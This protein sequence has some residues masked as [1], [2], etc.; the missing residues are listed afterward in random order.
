MV[1]SFASI[2][3]AGLKRLWLLVE[4]TELS[5]TAG[6]T[7]AIGLKSRLMVHGTP[8]FHR[9]TRLA[10]LETPMATCGNDRSPSQEVRLINRV[11]N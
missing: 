7:E 3:L 5:G 4:M 10:S 9:Q 2:G 6:P 8:H 1:H 11:I